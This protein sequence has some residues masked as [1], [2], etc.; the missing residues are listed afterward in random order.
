MAGG[1]DGSVFVHVFGK[2][3]GVGGKVAGV[4]AVRLP[5]ELE[6]DKEEIKES[7]HG[8]LGE[9]LTISLFSIA[10]NYYFNEHGVTSIRVETSRTKP[11]SSRLAVA[12]NKLGLA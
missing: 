3:S 4:D 6:P 5:K 8:G 1:V 9:F 11:S 2:V 12:R 7:K 10:G